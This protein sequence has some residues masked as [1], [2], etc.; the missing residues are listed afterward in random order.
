[1]SKRALLSGPAWPKLAVVL[2][3]IAGVWSVLAPL[4]GHMGPPWPCAL[5]GVILLVAATTLRL[6]P[7]Q[8]LG[9]GVIVVGIGVVTILLGRGGMAPGLTSVVG[10]LAAIG[11]H[12]RG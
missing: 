9:W 2:I 6:R 3:A 1:M 8:N 11:W 10:G 5:A 7:R 12:D 4:L